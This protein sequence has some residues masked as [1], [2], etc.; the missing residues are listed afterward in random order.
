MEP[1]VVT[2]PGV[3]PDGVCVV[4]VCVP[5]VLVLGDVVPGG[6]LWLGVLVCGVAV[7]E[8]C[9]ALG[10]LVVDPGALE[11]CPAASAP[12]A[13]SMLAN[14]SASNLMISLQ[15]VSHINC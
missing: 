1:G 5:V 7:V 11:V 2:T 10:G 8:P 15:I 6:V 9:V 3:D 4:F 12:V 13:Q 14:N